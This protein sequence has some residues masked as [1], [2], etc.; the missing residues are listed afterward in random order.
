MEFRSDFLESLNLCN[1]WSF[2][3]LFLVIPPRL[4][5]IFFI[6]VPPLHVFYLPFL[7]LLFTLFSIPFRAPYRLQGFFLIFPQH[8]PSNQ[9]KT[10]FLLSPRVLLGSFLFTFS[11]QVAPPDEESLVADDSPPPLAT[12][13]TPVPDPFTFC[14]TPLLRISYSTLCRNLFLAPFSLRFKSSFLVAFLAFLPPASSPRAQRRQ[15]LSLHFHASLS[16]LPVESEL[17]LR[18]DENCGCDPF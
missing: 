1:V 18:V 5:Q 12:F 13:L 16:F 4:V 14:L 11:S 8:N 9:L 15:P 10:V 6:R 2:E 7:P 17:V 3:A